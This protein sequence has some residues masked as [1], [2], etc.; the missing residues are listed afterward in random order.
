M[1]TRQE[2]RFA[3][4]ELLPF[5]D[6]QKLAQR[7]GIPLERGKDYQ[8]NLDRILNQADHD[9]KAAIIVDRALDLATNEEQMVQ[10]ASRSAAAAE[11]SAE[12]ARRSADAA[13]K[14]SAI[15]QDSFRFARTSAW[16]SWVGAVGA[17]LAAIVAITALFKCDGGDERQASINSTEPPKTC[18]VARVE[19][20]NRPS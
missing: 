19:H 1:A 3:L 9:A 8:A 12:H 2:R 10:A 15:A 17:I 18:R 20:L 7:L 14:S 4:E 13:E 11:E 5:R 16:A 6:Q